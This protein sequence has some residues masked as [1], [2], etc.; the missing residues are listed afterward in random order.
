ME[1][2]SKLSHLDTKMSVA[3]SE[4]RA[5][6]AV[7]AAAQ[8]AQASP[9]SSCFSPSRPHLEPLSPNTRLAPPIPTSR[10]SRCRPLQEVCEQLRRWA[11]KYKVRE[12]GVLVL[13]LASLVFLLTALSGPDPQPFAAVIA[14][15]LGWLTVYTYMLQAECLRLTTMVQIIQ[16]KG[17][18]NDLRTQERVDIEMAHIYHAHELLR[19]GG[20]SQKAVQSVLTASLVNDYLR[21]QSALRIY[22]ERF[23]PL[24]E[25]GMHWNLDKTLV[26]SVVQD[27]SCS[28]DGR[29]DHDSPASEV[30][31]LPNVHCHSPRDVS[32]E[33]PIPYEAAKASNGPAA[34][35]GM[36][37]AISK[38]IAS[39]EDSMNLPSWLKQIRH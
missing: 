3:S 32:L 20:G 28:P 35:S 29:C 2:T 36:A 9:H 30:G 22:A 31:D 7:A 38:T 18:L 19:P 14:A 21:L 34:S 26:A 13:G 6:Q 23:G 39:I 17:D 16:N 1:G 33:S 8:A 27:T 12:V 5:R 10:R 24:A 25:A 15:L 4:H 37:E 11:E